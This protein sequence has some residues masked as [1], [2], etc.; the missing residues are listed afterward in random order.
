MRRVISILAV[1]VIVTGVAVWWRQD[2]LAD[3]E[4]RTPL[5]VTGTA[6]VKPEPSLLTHPVGGIRLDR[7]GSLDV[8]PLFDAI[9]VSPCNV[10][11]ILEQE[12][13]SQIDGVFQE[14]V[15]ELGHKVKAGDLLG[16]LDGRQLRAQVQLLEI[17]ANSDAAEKIARAQ[18][19][20]ADTRVQYAVRANESGLRSVP[21]L[22]YKGYLFQRERFA[23]EMK[24]AREEREA[25]QKELEKAKLLLGLHELRSALSGEVIKIYKRNGEAVKQ[26][27]P[28]FRVAD[29]NRLRIEGLCKVQQA[30][31]LRAGMKSLVEPELRGEQ[32][33]E[34]AG[35]TGAITGLSMTHDGRWLASASD[36]RSV[37]I[38]SWPDGFRRATLPHPGE[39][40]AL[41]FAKHINEL[42]TGS[43]DGMIR[44]WSLP[45]SGTVAAPIVFSGHHDGTIRSIA[46]SAD[47]R[48]LATG[49]DDKRIGI[50]DASSGKHL[51][52]LHP[53]DDGFSTAHLGAVTS[54]NFTPDGHLISAARDNTLKAWKL[55]QEKGQ[56]A[57]SFAGRTGDA[58]QL[59]MTPDGKHV[60][61]DH[62]DELRILDWQKGANEGSLRARR[63]GRLQ[64]VAIVSPS[65]KII[66]AGSNN[67]RLQLWNVPASA[68]RISAFR[69]A[70]LKDQDFTEKLWNLTGYEI[71]HFLLPSAT[72]ANCAVFAPDES[73]F[74]TG[75]SD[76]V[77]RVWAIPA[78]Q[79][80]TRPLEAE[81]TFVGS[82]LE[83]GTDMVRVRAEMANPGD[84]GRRVRP[85]TYV[86]LRI[87]PEN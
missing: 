14:I 66:L 41:T 57:A 53:S 62:G 71:R 22:E 37:M 42:F 46:L 84:P 68:E 61:F 23:Q 67:G 49:G 13:S 43:S 2:T 16:R 54:L 44:R 87:Y 18:H 29:F 51:Y 50:W 64:N 27:E 36:D 30:D 77:I 74:F 86:S 34:L 35:H 24:K 73:V 12:V 10:T 25:A 17:K 8:K 75:G 85:G 48:F 15:V 21:E 3:P 52:W 63:Q 38:W 28:L 55:E 7:P 47:G 4:T 65:G 40:H 59:G 82:Q 72:V 26:A 9:Q 45:E 69:Q 58:G 19:D 31:L 11:P 5:Q 39:V 79:P 1:A 6:D 33:T 20:E 80:W 81:I 32:M 56:Q 70:K 60:L 76:K 83:R 78:A